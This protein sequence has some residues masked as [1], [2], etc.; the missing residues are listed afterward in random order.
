MKL[1]S[2]GAVLAAIVFIVVVTTAVD[3]LLHVLG[4][5]APWGQALDHIGSIIALSYR[6]PIGIAGGWITA[7]LAPRDPMR[8]VLILGVIGTVMATLGLVA[9]WNMDLG[10]R[11]YP[12]S[13]VVTALPLS[14]L[15]GRMY[16]PV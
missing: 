1:K 12:I 14:W 15:G 7:R 6:L 5:Y 9:T 10:P 16:R 4:V 13:L 2:V 11:W 8:H 3:Q